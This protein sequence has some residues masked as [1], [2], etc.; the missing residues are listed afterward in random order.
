[1]LH[2]TDISKSFGSQVLLDEASLHVK[3]GMRVGLVGPNGAGKTTLL[4]LIVGEMSLDGGEISARK[5]L[6]IGF[7]PQE[8]EEIADHAVIDEV[9]ASHVDILSAER[10]IAELGQ[11]IGH[12]YAGPGAASGAAAARRSRG[13]TTRAGR[14]SDRLRRRSRLRTRDPGAD[15]PARHGLQRRG[16]RPPDRRTLRRLAHAR[17]PLA[18]SARAA[19][20]ATHGR[21]H[22][23]P[24]P[25]EPAVVGGLPAHLAGRPR[26]DQPRPLLS[27][28][29]G[30]AHRRSRPGRHRSLRRRLRPLRGREEAALRGPGQRGQE[31]AAR[32][33][34]GRGLHPPLPSEEHQSQAGAAEDPAAGEDRAHRRSQPRAEEDQVPLPPT[35]PHRPGG[36]GD[37]ASAQGLRRQG[38]LQETRPGARA[39][40]EDRPGRSRTARANRP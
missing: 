8:I 16:F 26:G 33:R 39:G 3:P 6:R 35:A 31:P 17:R 38:G 2:L 13:A 34:F 18:A 21:A 4:R 29:H 20:P 14:P 23:S 5:D 12:A 27:Q 37:Q 40:G 7:L 9:L 10:R 19:R 1:M 22:Q 11:Q 30:H 28:P 15:H 24:R 36:G 32:D 25:R